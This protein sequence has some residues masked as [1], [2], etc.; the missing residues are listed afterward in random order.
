[1]PDLLPLNALLL[2]RSS[3]VKACNTDWGTYSDLLFATF[4]VIHEINCMYVSFCGKHTHGRTCLTVIER[5][6]KG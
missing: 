4:P 3:S 2:H 5:D 6:G 1:M